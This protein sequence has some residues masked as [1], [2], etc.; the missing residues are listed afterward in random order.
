MLPT[1]RRSVQRP[2]RRM[3]LEGQGRQYGYL[4]KSGPVAAAG[5]GGAGGRPDS[6]VLE[7]PVSKLGPVVGKEKRHRKALG[8]RGPGRWSQLPLTTEPREH[9]RLR[10]G[11]G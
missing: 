11:W 4:E 6:T 10:P 8:R 3:V 1:G 2:G 5:A 7:R 9:S